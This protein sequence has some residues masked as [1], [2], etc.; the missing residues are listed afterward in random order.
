MPK[1]LLCLSEWVMMESNSQHGP[2]VD[3]SRSLG[4]VI[5]IC[6]TISYHRYGYLKSSVYRIVY[7]MASKVEK[8]RESGGGAFWGI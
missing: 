3:E 1:Q 5:P 2:R 6:E 8:G 7:S 4:R